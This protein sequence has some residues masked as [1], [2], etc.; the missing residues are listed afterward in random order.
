[1]SRIHTVIDATRTAL[2]NPEDTSQAFRIAEALS[3][4]APERML[5]KFRRDTTGARLLTQRD[6][7]L[8]ALSDRESLE[9][10]PEG[11]LARA[12]LT[13]L[14][15]ENITAAG[16]VEASIE[17]ASDRSEVDAGSDLAFVRRRMRDTHDLW[18]TVSGYKGDLLGEASL[19]AFTF[20]QT[21]HPGVGFL[22]ALGMVFGHS[23]QRDVVYDGFKRGRR[24]KWM[25]AQDWIALLPRPLAEVRAK[26]GID[27]VPTYEE[28][29][30]PT[31][32]FARARS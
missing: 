5:V 25:V 3:F 11:S 22:A 13:F 16:L 9:A 28:V 24:A 23:G 17:G 18:H 15:S 4:G 1:M 32:R 14:D 19:L 10:M 7:L 27:Y 26:L 21:H 29:R 30:E 8:A 2:T 12:Y 20:A 6:D 31:H